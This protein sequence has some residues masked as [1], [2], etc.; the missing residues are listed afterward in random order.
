MLCIKQRGVV[1]M[2]FLDKL[3]NKR[4]QPKSFDDFK[5]FIKTENDLSEEQKNAIITIVKDGIRDGE[6]WKTIG[7]LIIM[8]A[9]IHT[10]NVGLIRVKNGIEVII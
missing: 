5:V 2:S 9:G 7:L 10:S 3:F 4:Q 8:N 1:P 6:E